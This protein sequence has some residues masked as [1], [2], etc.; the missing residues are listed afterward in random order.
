MIF[1]GELETRVWT[2]F[3]TRNAARLTV[4]AEPTNEPDT[5]TLTVKLN[6]HRNLAVTL[7]R[8]RPFFIGYMYHRPGGDHEYVAVGP[9]L[10]AGWQDYPHYALA[11]RN[12]AQLVWEISRP[13]PSLHAERDLHDLTIGLAETAGQLTLALERGLTPAP[14]SVLA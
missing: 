10:Y 3:L 6:R 5:L 13:W 7:A 14:S 12:N 4:D 1:S 8:D 2:A 9:E 11:L